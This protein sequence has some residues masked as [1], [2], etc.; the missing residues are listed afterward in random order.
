MTVVALG[1]SPEF[2]SLHKFSHMDLS[3]PGLTKV[4]ESIVNVGV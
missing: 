2:P 3:I 1:Y 4:F